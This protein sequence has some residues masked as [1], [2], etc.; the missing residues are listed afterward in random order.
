MIGFLKMKWAFFRSRKLL[1]QYDQVFFSNEAISAVWG[2]AP[3]TKT[4]YYA[5]SI[6]RHLFDLYAS[7]KSKVPWFAKVPY[8]VMAWLLRK[9]YITEVRHI[10]TV[11]VNAPHNQLRVREWI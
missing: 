2:I 7:Y 8:S 4:Y 5:H 11:L 10:D 9:L 6:S 1:E 3:G